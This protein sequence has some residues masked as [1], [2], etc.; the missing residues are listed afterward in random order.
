M[1]CKLF[2][3]NNESEGKFPCCNFSHGY[4]HKQNIGLAEAYKRGDLTGWGETLFGVMS[5]EERDYYLNFRYRD[6]K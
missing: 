2:G 6:K 5:D 3:C 1:K 4:A